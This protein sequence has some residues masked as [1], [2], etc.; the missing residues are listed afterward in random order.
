RTKKDIKG[1]IV[2]VSPDCTFLTPEYERNTIGDTISVEIKPKEGWHSPKLFY[3]SDLC[4]R[5]LKYSAKT[6]KNE[7][8][9]V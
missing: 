5:C 9:S 4:H 3:S 2:I 6:P 8:A 1:S 7:L